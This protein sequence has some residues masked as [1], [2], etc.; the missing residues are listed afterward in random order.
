VFGILIETRIFGE[1]IPYIAASG[2]L[3]AE[4]ALLVRLR[5]AEGERAEVFSM[6]QERVRDAA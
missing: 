6:A 1:L 3:M 5:G 2:A 4:S